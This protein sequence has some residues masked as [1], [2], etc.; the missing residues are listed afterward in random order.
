LLSATAYAEAQDSTGKEK[1]GLTVDS[2]DSFVAVRSLKM[3]D[4]SLRGQI[5][6][7]AFA[8]LAPLFVLIEVLRRRALK[9]AGGETVEEHAGMR[10]N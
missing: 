1:D 10:E 6:A 4:Q 5:V 7:G 3:P 2:A 9:R 8:I